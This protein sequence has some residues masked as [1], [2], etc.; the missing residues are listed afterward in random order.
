MI[1]FIIIKLDEDVKREDLE[2]A[3]V[4]PEPQ[5]ESIPVE[6][7]VEEAESA[8]EEKQEAVAVEKEE[9]L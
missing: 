6:E 9:E 3:V 7:V 2:K 1:R 8:S 5:T 4:I